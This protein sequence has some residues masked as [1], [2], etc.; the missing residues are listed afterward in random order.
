M[1]ENVLDLWILSKCQRISLK[2]RTNLQLSERLADIVQKTI[3]NRGHLE[4]EGAIALFFKY[5]NNKNRTLHNGTNDN[6]ICD[7]VQCTP[8]TM[9]V[10]LFFVNS[11]GFE[12]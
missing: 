6:I 1:V 11:V 8:Y 10:K 2:L 5:I 9:Q 7:S 12:L 4:L 3:K